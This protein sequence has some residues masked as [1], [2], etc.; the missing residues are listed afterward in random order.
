MF[1]AYFTGHDA[2]LCPVLG[3][4]AHRDFEPGGTTL[5]A[6]VIM[7]TLPSCHL[8]RAREGAGHAFRSHHNP[9]CRTGHGRNDYHR[10]R[11]RAAKHR[12][13]LATL[14]ACSGLSCTVTTGSPAGRGSTRLAGSFPAALREG[15]SVIY[16]DRQRAAGMAGMETGTDARLVAMM[17]GE[18][19]RQKP[20]WSPF[21]CPVLPEPASHSGL[22]RRV[23]VCGLSTCLTDRSQDMV[24]ASAA[25]SCGAELPSSLGSGSGGSGR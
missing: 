2:L 21:G 19:S 15:I 14:R 7:R 20:Q 11:R 17:P 23:S 22:A 16:H 3:T 25:F 13:D 18:R 1:D 8:G 12:H 24:D 9:T 10:R 6:I 5:P 4:A